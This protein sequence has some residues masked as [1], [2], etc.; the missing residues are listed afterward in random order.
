V[1]Q[2]MGLKKTKKIRTQING[3]YH[4]ISSADENK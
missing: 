2:N 4:D 3:E 1:K